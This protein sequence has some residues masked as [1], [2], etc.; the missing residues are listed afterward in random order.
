MAAQSIDLKQARTA[1]LSWIG[2]EARL[3]LF[4]WLRSIAPLSNQTGR[5][6][7]WFQRVHKP[8]MESDISRQI[9]DVAF[10]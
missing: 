1:L 5:C 6:Q 2:M 4:S 10:K 3:I 8:V 7:P 9:H